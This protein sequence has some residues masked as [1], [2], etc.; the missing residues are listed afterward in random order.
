VDDVKRRLNVLVF[1]AWYP[2]PEN[3]AAVSFLREHVR[4]VALRHNVMVLV[5]SRE[6]SKIPSSLLVKQ[7]VE[8]GVAILRMKYRRSPVPKTTGFRYLRGVV[9]AYRSVLKGGFSPDLIHAHFYP[10]ALPALILGKLFRVPVLLTEHSASFAVGLNGV[11]KLEAKFALRRMRLLIAVSR[12]LQ[13]QMESCGVRGE[14]RVIPNPVDTSIFFPDPSRRPSAGER[15][16][17]LIVGRLH[18]IKG[19]PTLLNGLALLSRSREDFSLDIVGDGELRPELESLACR[20]G[21]Q[22]H[23]TFHGFK[24]RETVADFMRRSRVFVLASHSEN[25]PCAL[26]EALASGLPVVSSDVGGIREAVPKHMGIFFPKGDAQA[27]AEALSAVL[28]R[29]DS[30]DPLEIA[31]YARARFSLEAV[32]AQID[33]AYT[34]VLAS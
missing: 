33:R 6:P 5:G 18:S 16:H 15:K 2:S 31:A 17:I 24:P 34:Q 25:C 13:D 29:L 7:A 8:D 19:F 27:L 26:L 11:T 14:F 21:L 9:S 28:D 4:T 20:L 22:R 3:P 23:V 30:Y 12:S 10:A 1:P 32:G